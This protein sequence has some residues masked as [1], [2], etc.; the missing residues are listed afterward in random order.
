MEDPCHRHNLDSPLL[1]RLV[2]LSLEPCTASPF[3][4]ALLCFL[5][6]FFFFSTSVSPHPA[7]IRGKTLGI[8]GYGRVGSQLSVLAESLGAKVIFYD[9][10]P[11]L[12]MGNAKAVRSMD[13]LLAA[14]DFVSLHV[15]LTMVTT[16]MVGA[17]VCMRERECDCW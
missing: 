10:V 11:V 8:I 16:W 6:F 12:P 14:S 3:A 7:E 9:N 15:P 17:R 2:I 4:S 13:E 5:F 1:I